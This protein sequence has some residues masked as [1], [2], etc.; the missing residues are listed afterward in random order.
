MRSFLILALILGCA[1]RSNTADTWLD[2]AEERAEERGTPQRVVDT[3]VFQNP[4]MWE[5]TPW[6]RVTDGPE[7]PVYVL[8]SASGDACVVTPQVWAGTM[9]E[10]YV[11]CAQWRR[12]RRRR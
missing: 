9:L 5:Q 1:A 3:G 8:I 10:S 12:A 7:Y 2:E 6:W 11:R 4:D